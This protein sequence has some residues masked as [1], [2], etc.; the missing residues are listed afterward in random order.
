VQ[1]NLLAIQISNLITDL[2]HL[3]ATIQLLPVAARRV[4]E[5]VY[6]AREVFCAAEEEVIGRLMYERDSQSPTLVNLRNMSGSPP[7][8][9]NLA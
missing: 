5:R 6:S 2:V 7:S 4:R 9:T 3:F 8:A 1:R